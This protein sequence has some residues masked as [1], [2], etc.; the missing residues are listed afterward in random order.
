MDTP[1]IEA[2]QFQNDR[3][4]LTPEQCEAL[5]LI[6]TDPQP[7]TFT[8]MPSMTREWGLADVEC[9]LWER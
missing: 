8:A 9:A 4:Y 1:P 7:T 5:G 2:C 3:W 6:Q